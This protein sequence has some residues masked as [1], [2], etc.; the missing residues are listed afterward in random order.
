MLIKTLIVSGLLFNYSC[1][2]ERKC[3]QNIYTVVR[4]QKKKPKKD[5]TP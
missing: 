1:E 2:N 3:Q 5:S 4:K